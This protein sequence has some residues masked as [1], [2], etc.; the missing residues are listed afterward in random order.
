M[1]VCEPDCER[2]CDWLRVAGCDPE[3]TWLRVR[4]LLFVLLCVPVTDC[5][6]EGV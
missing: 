4:L 6:N 2:L 3:S 5:V 1:R